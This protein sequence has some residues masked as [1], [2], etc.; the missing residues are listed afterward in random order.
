MVVAVKKTKAVLN[1]GGAISPA[2]RCEFV[3][4]FVGHG[5]GEKTQ[6]GDDRLDTSNN[7]YYGG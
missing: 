1:C 4:K 3:S 6:D 2:R 7:N 5:R